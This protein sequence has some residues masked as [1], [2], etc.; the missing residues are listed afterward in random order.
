MQQAAVR[1]QSENITWV[2]SMACRDTI[3]LLSLS[4]QS[5]LAICVVCGLFQLNVNLCCLSPVGCLFVCLDNIKNIAHDVYCIFLDQFYFLYCMLFLY[6]MFLMYF[7]YCTFL[8]YS[9]YCTFLMYF[10]YPKVFIV[11]LLLHVFN[12]FFFIARFQCI[13]CT[14]GF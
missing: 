8:M 9:L 12:V 4:R 5:V 11:F 1:C 3:G 13:S 6:C 7:L 2:R 10:L 14:A